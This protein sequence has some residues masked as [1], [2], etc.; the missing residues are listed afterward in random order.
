MIYQ[1]LSGI[2]ILITNDDSINS[3][4]IKAMERIANSI[5]PD[6][7]V[8]APEVQQ[9]GKGFS[10]TFDHVLRVVERSPRR[11][12]VSGTPADCTFIAINEILKSKAPDLVL[13]GINHGA[14]FGDYIGLSGTL[15]AAFAAASQGI[16]AIAVSQACT[17]ESSLEKFPIA[18]HY[19]AKIIKKLMSIEWPDGVCMNVNFPDAPV[20]NISGI[21]VVKQGNL[22][23]KWDIVKRLDP[24][25]D[26][27]YWMH[28]THASKTF[29]SDTD[30]DVLAKKNAITI[31]PLQCRHELN[32]EV[33]KL[34]DL[35]AL[36]V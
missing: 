21:K 1:S 29:D 23:V 6:V 26:A 25:G 33:D 24:V 20:G 12:S 28:S 11:F 5:T 16:R 22:D 36:N 3:Q 35:F 31:T 7:W 2:R 14:N 4:G 17:K 32:G 30:V 15:G 27:Y 13:S 9:S 34:E 10:V 18:D 19:L 8:V